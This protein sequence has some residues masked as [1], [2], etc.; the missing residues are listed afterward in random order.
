MTAKYTKALQ[1]QM[2]KTKD[3]RIRV[4]NEILNNIK[5]IKLYGWERAFAE[6]VFH[7]RNQNELRLLRK[8]GLI[9]S[10]SNFLWTSTPFL[11]AF[12][13]FASFVATNSRTLTSEIIFP[14]IS[15][16]QLL[17]FPL[18]AV[19]N[20]INSIIEAVVSV[21]RLEEFLA[22]DELDSNARK[23]I[24][25]KDDPQGTPHRGDD[26]VII[27][28]GDFRW[29]S[30]STEPILQNIDLTVKKGE[31]LAVIGRV[32][33]G[34]SSL[35]G[36]MLGE[37]TRSDGSV[38]IRGD[39]AY[40]P[41]SSWILSA[42]VKDNIVFGHRV[43]LTFYEEVLDACALRSDLRVLPQGD[44][45]EVGEKGVSLSGGQK[46][47]ICLARACY[48]RA[49]IHL[50]DDPLSAV[51]SHVGRH[52][53][54]RVIG[55][56]G[57]LKDKARIFCTNAVNFLPQTDHVI[58]LR[59]GII[60]ERGTYADAMANSSSEL[61]KLIT[62]L[63]KQSDKT[64]E[65]VLPTILDGSPSEDQA[66]SVDDS[67][68]DKE[69]VEKRM[70]I[71][72]MST[73][74]LRRASSVSNEQAKRDALRDLRES[75]KPKE[76]TERGMV[77]K[78]VYKSYISAASKF[79][80]TTFLLCMI[81]GQGFSILS[82]YVLRFWAR[83][84][85]AAGE[86]TKVQT[87]LVTYGVIGVSSLFLSV[88]SSVVLKIHC[89]LRA[90][91]KLHDDAFTALMRSPLGFFE[92][93]PTG[94]ILNLFS[95]DISVLDEMLV[96]GL[97]SFFR[98]VRAY[99]PHT[100]TILTDRGLPQIIQVLGVVVLIA[101]S[102]PFVLV[103]FVPLGF[104]YR[105]VMRWLPFGGVRLTADVRRHYLS[106]SRELKRLDAV[107]RSPIFSFL[108][109]T[110]AGLPVIRVSPLV[111][112]VLTETDTRPGFRSDLAVPLEK[113]SPN[114]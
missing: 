9:Q 8:I 77:K 110:L 61:Y 111:S 11:V 17:S 99:D 3:R 79:G 72:R 49:D 35:L 78:A 85:T 24:L 1:R 109:E 26:V 63:G 102:A 101:I 40:F 94:R 69:S 93:T 106:T 28:D 41:Q 65:S 37:M 66:E 20:V 56:N 105:L 19:S 14:A 54:D 108:G 92:V 38:T 45:T 100:R 50:L 12:A 104:L 53:F 82:N 75:A 95:R 87:Y 44:M 67:L 88:T 10:G 91:R 27:K 112:T 16:F 34:K 71:R 83:Q 86:T 103:V 30:D 98:T 25:P 21:G 81:L 90:S 68:D 73:V 52:I 33:D 70:T 60:L 46:A 18:A 6:K 39:V 89:A 31:L 74:K 5:S 58:M 29:M 42:T 96:N 48:A 23:F 114:R 36:A 7:A 4:M 59:Q 32:G 43:D 55:P 84:N 97:G 57:L 2:M 47:R 64:E 22:A 80:F 107:S 76:H 15:L 51:D 113:R 62:G 13:T